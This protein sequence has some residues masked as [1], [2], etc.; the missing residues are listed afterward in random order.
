MEY[1]ESWDFFSYNPHIGKLQQWGFHSS[2]GSGSGILLQ[3]ILLEFTLHGY[4][5]YG[6]IPS[7]PMLSKTWP[8]PSHWRPKHDK[9]QLGLCF[10][11]KCNNLSLV[12]KLTTA[13]TCIYLAHQLWHRLAYISSG[14]GLVFILSKCQNDGIVWLRWGFLRYS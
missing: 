4:V 8:V 1:M 9:R 6:T 13:C 5:F 12:N 14:E 7:L 2:S 11:H 10:Q 3:L